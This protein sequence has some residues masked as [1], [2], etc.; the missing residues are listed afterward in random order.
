[1][2]NPERTTTDFYPLLLQNSLDYFRISRSVSW[3]FLVKVRTK[4]QSS[5]LGEIEKFICW[6]RNNRQIHT[7]QHSTRHKPL[8]LPEIT[9]FFSSIQMGFIFA[10]YSLSASS[11]LLRDPV[12]GRSP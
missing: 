1:M 4:I 6:R 9:L 10:I 12:E 11:F 3:V 7:E 8:F 2:S 5:L